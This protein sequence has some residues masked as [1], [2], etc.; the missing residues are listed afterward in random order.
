VTTDLVAPAELTFLFTDMEASTRAWDRDLSAMDAAQRRHDV[1]LRGAI[2]AHGGRIF[3]TAGDGMAAAFSKADEAL[4]AA[5][6]AQRSLLRE[7]WPTAAPVRV[8]MGLHTG[9][10]I[11]RDGDFF[12]PTVIRAARLMSLVGGGRIICSAAT[13]DALPAAVPDVQLLAVGTVQ[14][15]GLSTPEV[16]LAVR[17][18]GLPEAGTPV[19][20]ARPEWR[21]PVITS[22]LIARDQLI[23]DVAARVVPATL[24]TLVGAGGVGKTRLAVAVADR[25]APVHGEQVAW[26]DLTTLAEPLAIVYELA[27]LLGVRV[28]RGEDLTDKVAMAI[29]DRD[30]VVVLDNCEHVRESVRLLVRVLLE[31]CPRLAVLATSRELLG[32]PAE[33]VVTVGPLRSSGVESAAVELLIERL[34]A[35]RVELDDAELATLSEIASRL[36]GIPLALELV[37]ARCRRLG[38]IEVGRRLPGRLDQLADPDRAARHQTLDGTIG[39]SYA[40]LR[41]T[42]QAL[43]RTLAVFSG[44]FD[45]DAAEAVAGHQAVDVEATVTSLLDKSLI[46]RDGRRF[47]LLEMTRDF[48]SRRRAEAG[49]LEASAAHSRYVRTRVVEIRNGLHGRDESTWVEQLDAVWPDV[50]TTMRRALDDDDADAAIELVSHLAFEAFWRR[51]EAF[52]WIDEATARWG[53]R[54]GPHRHELLGAAGIAAWTQADV[55][56]GLRL[57]TAA[58]AADP[59]PGTALDCL[60]EGAAIGAFM[61]SGRFDDGMT[62]ARQALTRLDVGVDDWNRA[63]MHANLAN[64]L[65]IS[66]THTAELE[67]EVD[68]SIG[69]AF[70]TGNPTAIAYAYLVHALATSTTDPAMCRVALEHARAYA[71]EVDNHWV[72]TTAATTIAMA[73][74]DALDEAAVA[75]ALE[76]AD[77]LHRTGW[78]THAWCA[79]WGVITG[80]WALNRAEAAALVL[81]GCKASGVAR[82]AYQHVPADL[83]D[84]ASATASFRRLGGHL[85]FDDLLAIAS[86]RRQLPLLP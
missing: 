73:P 44:T 57:G 66:G 78:T 72:L 39:W 28:P 11:E 16:A 76:A 74:L 34:G 54:P 13:G 69:L 18:P 20:D 3:S 41:P 21:R 62:V 70:A 65:G 1:I 51:P 61:F 50:R 48:A 79:M 33:H 84:D 19:D 68:T 37:A 85:S 52:T 31:R 81:G 77:D 67:H 55:E 24:V 75:L 22:S 35:R 63:V 6:D 30:L 80:L 12:G 64:A 29:G 25:I 5:V 38:I 36:D 58:L 71:S 86:G 46:E 32:L 10:A 26:L 47:R 49:E 4:A 53:D 15:K 82:L 43:L 83:E 7:P 8:R 40:M 2:D 9:A 23:A 42:E 60:P 59:E 27:A 56:A 17:A 14:L 45:L